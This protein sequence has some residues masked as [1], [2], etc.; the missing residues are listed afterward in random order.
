MALLLGIAVAHGYLLASPGTLPW[1]LVVYSVGVIAGCLLIAGSIGFGRDPRVPQAG[2]LLG[3]LLSGVILCVDILT[4]LASVPGLAAVTGRWDFAPATFALA[5][6]GAFI[7]VHGS[8]VLGINV[9]YPQRQHWQ[10]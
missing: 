7:A 4:R 3:S 6:A 8:V 9:A 10:D 1:Y 2:W 5:F